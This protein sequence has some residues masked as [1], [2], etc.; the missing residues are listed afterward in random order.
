MLIRLKP[1]GCAIHAVAQSRRSRTV[2]EDVPQ[3]RA[4][5]GAAN[6][7]T[8]HTVRS[9][10]DLLHST[11]DDRLDGWKKLGQPVPESNLVSERNSG[12]P[13]AMQR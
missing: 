3:V 10:R 13:Q 2:V 6:L 1:Q 4:A 12:S 11:S 8:H 5:A 7:D 9:I